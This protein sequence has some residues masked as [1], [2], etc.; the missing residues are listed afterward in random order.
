MKA[1]DALA[2]MSSSTDSS[3]PGDSSTSGL[4]HD[5]TSSRQP[6]G[7]EATKTPSR[8]SVT[9]EKTT[10]P[11]HDDAGSKCPSQAASVEDEYKAKLAEKRRLARERAEQEA[12]EAK[13]IAE[14]KR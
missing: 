3:L 11:D 9:K 13:R 6:N 4:T 10:L 7:K 14:E 8:T 12:A 2:A 1:D 5:D